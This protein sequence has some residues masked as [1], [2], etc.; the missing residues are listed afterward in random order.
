VHPSKQ[1]A[2]TNL[3]FSFINPPDGRLRTKNRNKCPCF[4]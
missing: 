4:G 1:H 3:A 2:T